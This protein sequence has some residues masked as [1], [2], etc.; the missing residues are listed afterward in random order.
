MKPLHPNTVA[1]IPLKLDLPP[2]PFLNVAGFVDFN[3]RYHDG[4]SVE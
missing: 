4:V 1:T 3:G 2:V